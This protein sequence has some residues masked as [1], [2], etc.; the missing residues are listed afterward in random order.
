M[1]NL[2]KYF[3]TYDLV[4]GTLLWAVVN[5][6]VPILAVEFTKPLSTLMPLLFGKSNWRLTSKLRFVSL[7]LADEAAFL[8]L[9]LLC[10]L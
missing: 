8:K 2:V 5:E 7:P 9:L 1:K 10:G 6:G 3:I 4:T